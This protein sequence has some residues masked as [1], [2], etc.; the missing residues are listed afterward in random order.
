[1]E[2]KANSKPTNRI[3]FGKNAFDEHKEI[4]N[5]ID[6]TF[7][8]INSIEKIETK[9]RHLTSA[10]K[11]FI[12][13][14]KAAF[15][16]TVFESLSEQMEKFVDSQASKRVKPREEERLAFEAGEHAPKSTLRPRPPK[17]EGVP[18]MGN[19][20]RYEDVTK[21]ISSKDIKKVDITSGGTS[22]RDKDGKKKTA[23][24]T[25]DSS[26]LNYLIENSIPLNDIIEK[27]PSGNFFNEMALMFPN[28]KT[29]AETEKYRSWQQDLSLDKNKFGPMKKIDFKKVK[30]E[31]EEVEKIKESQEQRKKDISAMKKSTK[32]KV[33]KKKTTTKKK[34]AKKSG[35]KKTSKKKTTKR[36]KNVKQ[37]KRRSSSGS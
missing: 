30:T 14:A 10:K 6:D 19:F 32:K 8:L 2:L 3:Y 11:K 5:A 28:E 35:K 13:N 21:P 16:E 15:K 25:V 1:M 9:S 17:R 22:I 18:E 29:K 23:L 34:S 24:A 4:E 12:E 7:A 26:T 33:S 31:L 20:S 36:S 37:N 27:S